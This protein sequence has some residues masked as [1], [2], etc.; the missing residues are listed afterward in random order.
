MFRAIEAHLAGRGIQGYDAHSFLESADILANFLDHS[1]QFVSEEG[2]WHNH[3]SMI[4]DLKLYQLGQSARRISS[5]TQFQSRAT[6]DHHCRF[7]YQTL[8]LTACNHIYF[9]FHSQFR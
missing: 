5:L 6:A 8:I 7:Q 4:A 2:W 1:S 9:T 3:E